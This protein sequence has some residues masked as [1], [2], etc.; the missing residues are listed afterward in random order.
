MEVIGCTVQDNDYE[1]I[2]LVFWL[3]NGHCGLL[4]FLSDGTK[5]H[6][7]IVYLLELPQKVLTET[8]RDGA[9]RNCRTINLP[10]RPQR[11][12]YRL[13]KIGIELLRISHEFAA[14][15][16]NHHEKYTQG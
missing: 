7:E 15:F 16:D 11:W 12:E 14:W 5:R 8:L 1:I 4:W 2:R 10:N 9:Y 3:A 6:S 13:T